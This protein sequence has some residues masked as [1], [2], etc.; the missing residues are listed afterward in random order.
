MKRLNGSLVI[1][2]F[3]LPLLLPSNSFPI[4]DGTKKSKTIDA[5]PR[6]I[7]TSSMFEHWNSKE[8]KQSRTKG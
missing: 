1:F 6:K 7:Y 3:F 5:R 8:S 4:T 2:V